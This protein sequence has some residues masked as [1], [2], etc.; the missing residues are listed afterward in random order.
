MSTKGRRAGAVGPGT[1]K[2]AAAALLLLGVLLLA[3]CDKDD[4]TGTGPQAP[5]AGVDAGDGGPSSSDLGNEAGDAQGSGDAADAPADLGMERD[6]GGPA[7]PTVRA[8]FALGPQGRM[9]FPN[10][11]F[12]TPDPGSPTGLR[13]DLREE[14]TVLFDR[15]MDVLLGGE[16]LL[17]WLNDLDGFSPFADLLVGLEATI[18]PASLPVTAR[19][20]TLPGSP[21]FLVDIQPGSPHQGE[22][23]PISVEYDHFRDEV[24]GDVYLLKVTPLTVLRSGNRYGLVVRSSVRALDTT[25]LGMSEDF[26]VV[27]GLKPTPPD[28]PA[29]EGLDRAREQLKPLIE[30]L[31]AMDP[32]LTPEDLA[33]ASVFTTQASTLILRAIS[34]FLRGEQAPALSVDLDPD[35]DSLPDLYLPEDLPQLPEEELEDLSSVGLVLRG[36]F[37]A[38]EFRGEEGSI[39]PDE[40][41]R[42][43]VEMIRK[44]PFL[45][46]LP[47]DEAMAPCPVVILQ[48]GHSLRKEYLLFLA[49]YFAE[50]GIATAAIDAVGH[51]ELEGTGS[52]MNFTDPPLVRG[53]FMQTVANLLSFVQVLQSLSELDLLP[54]GGGNG[55]P[56]LDL[57][58]KLGFIGESLGAISGAMLAALEPRVGAAVLNEPAAGLAYLVTSYVGTGVQERNRLAMLEFKG[59]VQTLFDQADPIN[60]ARLLAQ[61]PL[62]GSAPRQV[63]IQ[64]VAGG[65]FMEG[66]VIEN[67]ARGIGMPLVC[68]CPASTDELDLS[69]VGAPVD[70]LGLF[71]F[72]PAKHGF[73]L[74]N[75]EHPESSSAARYQAARFFESFYADGV[76][77]IVDPWPE[78]GM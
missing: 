61:E 34:D 25:R 55:S 74:A 18:D 70:S 7:E 29:R 69:R 63:L 2:P 68:P 72:E 36:T 33:V 35:G 64:A 60:Y 27:A 78:N 4:G 42:P 59:M 54:G 67:L 9:P 39:V 5:D 23:H 62:G 24:A 31:A 73:L 41:G 50:R 32:P 19:E 12:T 76:G 28:H 20:T 38:P 13:L 47:A 22:L 49:G 43:V 3:A 58:A 8:L 14:N 15:A 46:A 48:H 57:Q 30:Q 51:G 21:V 16:L 56:D 1:W 37:D 66:G 65:E 17:G 53:S 77:V 26:S 11:I 75:D 10:D 45:L 52:F 6:Q 40:S 44:I 71:C